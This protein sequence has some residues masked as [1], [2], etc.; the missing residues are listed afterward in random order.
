MRCEP[1]CATLPTGSLQ[2]GPAEPRP[3][4]TRQQSPTLRHDERYDADQVSPTGDR[5]VCLAVSGRP[6]EE[7]VDQGRP[8][9]APVPDGLPTTAEDE[10]PVQLGRQEGV[11]D[12]GGVALT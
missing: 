6:W 7:L 2:L 12:V 3:A 1:C 9:P 4:A 10:E 11:D 5:T 8:Q